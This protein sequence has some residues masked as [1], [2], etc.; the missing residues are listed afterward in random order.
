MGTE[1]YAKLGINDPYSN[2]VAMDKDKCDL[3]YKEF[4]EEFK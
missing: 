4:K 1:K 2:V 3:L